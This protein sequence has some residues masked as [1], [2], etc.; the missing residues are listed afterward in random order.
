[1]TKLFYIIILFWTQAAIAGCDV[2]TVSLRGAWGQ[3]G[4]SVEIADTE[5]SRSRGL[6]FRDS[7]ARRS[8]MLFVYDAPQPANFWMKNT[9]I[10]LD[11]IFVDDTGVVTFIHH[12]AIPGD[13]TTIHGGLNV[14]AVLEINGGLADHFGVRVGDQMRH[15]LINQKTAI[16]AC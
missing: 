6:M 2:G 3:I 7:M 9:L 4:F 8:G 1:M 16:W 13:L 15:Q 14:A 10:P 11:I 12:N 5:E